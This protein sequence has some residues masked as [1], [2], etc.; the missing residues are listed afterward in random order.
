M[1]SQVHTEQKGGRFLCPGSQGASCYLKAFFNE[2]PSA[3]SS[4]S[5]P[6]PQLWTE[7][8]QDSFPASPSVVAISICL[9]RNHLGSLSPL[10][11]WL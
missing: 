8:K 5:G 6:I 7:S 10:P 11:Q 2:R 1:Y 9:R 4:R 3:V